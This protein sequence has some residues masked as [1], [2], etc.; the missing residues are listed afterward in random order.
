MKATR[1]KPTLTLII[2]INTL[3]HSSPNYLRIAIEFFVHLSYIPSYAHA[4]CSPNYVMIHVARTIVRLC[5]RKDFAS[6]R[7]HRCHLL[8]GAL[9]LGPRF[10]FTSPGKLN[11]RSPWQVRDYVPPRCCLPCSSDSMDNSSTRS[12]EANPRTLSPA[13]MYHVALMQS[14]YTPWIASYAQGTRQWFKRKYGVREDVAE[15]TGPHCQPDERSKEAKADH[16]TNGKAL[17]IWVRD[18]LAYIARAGTPPN[19]MPRPIPTI[20]W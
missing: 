7:P 3:F 1:L 9:I 15:R 6:R 16:E 12:E 5:R 8:R 18:T 11:R 20:D 4:K 17:V 14:L 19:R 2:I 10:V 13:M